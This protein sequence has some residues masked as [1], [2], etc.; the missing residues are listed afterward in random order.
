MTIIILIAKVTGFGAV[1]ASILLELSRLNRRRIGVAGLILAF[2]AHAAEGWVALEA[3]AK[4][5]AD[6]VARSEALAKARE[7][8]LQA[9]VERQRAQEARLTAEKKLTGATRYEEAVLTNVG[10]CVLVAGTSHSVIQNTARTTQHRC[11]AAME[12]SAGRL[13]ADSVMVRHEVQ[14]F[15]EWLATQVVGA[16]DSGFAQQRRD[17]AQDREPSD[18][19]LLRGFGKVQEDSKSLRTEV[20]DAYK[21]R[22]EEQA[23]TISDLQESNRDLRSLCMKSAAPSRNVT[24]APSPPQEEAGESTLREEPPAV[25]VREPDGTPEVVQVQPVVLAPNSG[26]SGQLLQSP[27]VR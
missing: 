8:E 22:L 21:Q 19:K 24:E 4:A 17:L 6:E 27:T 18:E 2:C 23:R 15:S 14:T 16:I 1:A 7:K 12:T 13:H 10:A 11:V 5:K 9:E 3:E 25:P 20:T 26:P